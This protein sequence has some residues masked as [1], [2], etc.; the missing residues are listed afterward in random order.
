VMMTV[1]IYASFFFN[2]PTLIGSFLFVLF[3][4]PVIMFVFIYSRHFK[5]SCDKKLATTKKKRQKP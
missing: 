2:C 5:R 1:K 3:F 4:F